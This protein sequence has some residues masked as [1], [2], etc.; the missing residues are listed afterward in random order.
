MSFLDIALH[1]AARG[2]RVFPVR[3]GAKEPHIRDYP[4]LATTDTAH[5][6]PRGCHHGTGHGGNGLCKRHGL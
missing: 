6:I 5:P 1:N 3:A 2:L 4:D